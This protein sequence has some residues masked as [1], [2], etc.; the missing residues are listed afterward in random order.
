[1]PMRWRK[2]VGIQLRRVSVLSRGNH[3]ATK[4]RSMARR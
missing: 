2:M 3:L 4:A 1:M